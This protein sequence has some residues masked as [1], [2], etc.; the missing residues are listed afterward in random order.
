MFKKESKQSKHF[1]CLT[2]PF[3]IPPGVPE[4]LRNL[5]LGRHPAVRGDLAIAR[6]EVERA[7]GEALASPAH[8]NLVGAAGA[9]LAVG[10]ER[11]T[12][13]VLPLHEFPVLEDADDR[14][15]FG[16]VQMRK[17]GL[18]HVAVRLS[19]RQEDVVAALLVDRELVAHSAIDRA[20]AERQLHATRV[21]R[22]ARLRKRPRPRRLRLR[23]VAQRTLVDTSINGACVCIGGTD[24][25][26][27]KPF[28][29]DSK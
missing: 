16:G 11:V 17:L 8:A 14:V 20:L 29:F 27:Q 19:R 3:R 9:E 25:S 6:D 22:H 24:C 13:V 5:V 7:D 10:L 18:A 23:R 1:S 12:F 15:R 4:G 26:I 2:L 21:P 28:P